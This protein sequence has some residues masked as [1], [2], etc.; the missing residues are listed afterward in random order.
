MSVFKSMS[1]LSPG[2][3]LRSCVVLL[4]SLMWIHGSLHGEEESK[5]KVLTKWSDLKGVEGFEDLEGIDDPSVLDD[6]ED[7]DDLDQFMGLPGFEG[8]EGDTMADLDLE[9]PTWEFEVTLSGSLGYKDN[10]LLRPVD[11]ESSGFWRTDLESLLWRFPDGKTEF[12]SMLG[13]TDVRYFSAEETDG[14][15]SAF[16]HASWDWQTT[17]WSTLSLP[18]QAIYQDQVLDM[19]ETA[20]H[21]RIGQVQVFSFST[22]PE[23]TVAIGESLNLA[24]AGLVRVD[25]YRDRLDDFQDTGGQIHASYKFGLWG[26]FDLSYT[27]FRRDYK[28]RVQYTAGG[29][30]ELGTELKADQRQVDG[31]FDLGFSPESE[32]EIKARAGFLEYRDNGSGYFDYDRSR[33]GLDLTWTPGPWRFLLRGSLTRFDYKLQTLWNDAAFQFEKR[34]KED[35][36]G[37]FR[38]E[39]DLS[40]ALRWH[41]DCEGEQSVTNDFYGSYDS[42]AVY[43][44]VSWTF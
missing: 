34:E 5:P 10:I 9:L 6:I 22:D 18:G 41:L 31:R 16:F 11:G 21:T 24:I 13:F 29:R 20:D 1:V 8:L 30:P 37:Q 40:D 26:D 25:H 27:A 36:Y 14:E 28:D 3:P 17:E 44:G 4:I 32:W 42:V 39:R 35:L 23:W 2:R 19:S 12:V 15:Q 33:I 7:I 38:I 43:S